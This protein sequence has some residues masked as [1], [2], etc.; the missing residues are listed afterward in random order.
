MQT[1][2]PSQESSCQDSD[3][4][5]YAL[6]G[7]IAG[8][9]I[10]AIVFSLILSPPPLD[11]PPINRLMEAALHEFTRTLGILMVGLPLCGIAGA[12]VSVVLLS[13]RCSNKSGKTN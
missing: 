10:G 8:V 13:E 11:A 9:A 6:F 12:F 2:Q 7:A 5:W 3:I 1:N 4:G